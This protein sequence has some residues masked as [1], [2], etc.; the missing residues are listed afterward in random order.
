MWYTKVKLYPKLLFLDFLMAVFLSF[1]HHNH[2]ILSIWQLRCPDQFSIH[3]KLFGAWPKTLSTPPPIC[4]HWRPW[5]WLGVSRVSGFMGCCI[6]FP[7]LSL[8]DWFL[9]SFS[10]SALCYSY[11]GNPTHT[12]VGCRINPSGDLKAKVLS[13]QGYLC[14]LSRQITP[15]STLHLY[16]RAPK[17]STLYSL[18]VPLYSSSASSSSIQRGTG[19][20]CSGTLPQGLR[21]IQDFPEWGGANSVRSSVSWQ[22]RCPEQFSQCSWI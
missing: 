14:R 2:Q 11:G 5:H 8:W 16:S 19:H 3:M 12:L 7:R 1:M 21:Q 15:W 6:D 9:N 13:H 10:N 17:E 20:L 18:L 22:W 4:R